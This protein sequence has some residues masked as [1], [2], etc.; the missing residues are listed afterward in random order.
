MQCAAGWKVPLGSGDTAFW[1][2]VRTVL[3]MWWKVNLV[4]SQWEAPG[5]NEVERV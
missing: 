2:E 3:V 5:G 4:Y 1:D